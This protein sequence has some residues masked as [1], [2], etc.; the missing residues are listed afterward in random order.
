MKRTALISFGH[1]QHLHTQAATLKAVVSAASND[2]IAME[3]ENS[4]FESLKKYIQ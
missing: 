1:L 2:D 3:S 4:S